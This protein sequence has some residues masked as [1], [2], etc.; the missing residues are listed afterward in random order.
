M[1]IV[2]LFSFLLSFGHISL[3]NAMIREN[4][5]QIKNM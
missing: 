4:N 5:N 2:D 3:E 1:C